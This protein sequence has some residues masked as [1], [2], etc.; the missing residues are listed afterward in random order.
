MEENN[1]KKLK[2]VFADNKVD[3]A[4]VGLLNQVYE[5]TLVKNYPPKGLSKPGD[6]IPDLI[7]FTGGEDVSPS[8]YGELT[9]KFTHNNASRDAIEKNMFNYNSFLK[10]PKLGI[11]RGAQFLTVSS[12]GRLIQ[13][14]TGHGNITHR[15]QLEKG[16]ILEIPSDH[17]QMMFPYNMHK[18]KYEIIGYSERHLSDTY[19]DGTN[20]NIKLPNSFFEPEIVFY[21]YT[22]SLC[23]QSHPEWDLNGSFCP[24]ILKMIDSYLFNK[25]E[26]KQEEYHQDQYF[27]EDES[28][29]QYGGYDNNNEFKY[30]PQPERKDKPI[31]KGSLVGNESKPIDYWTSKGIKIVETGSGLPIEEIEPTETKSEDLIKY[32]DEDFFIDTLLEKEEVNNLKFDEDGKQV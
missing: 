32:Y 30:V 21:K 12:G 27:E 29:N 2:I 4:I 7:I 15:I 31:K 9:G 11:C 26:D 22:N 10:I 5:T 20:E 16:G 17:H 23:I 8:M 14:V 1:K 18:S 19:L 6:I 13:H 25:K 24:F 3:Q 28:S